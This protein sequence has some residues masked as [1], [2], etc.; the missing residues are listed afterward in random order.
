MIESNKIIVQRHLNR[1]KSQILEKDF[2]FLLPFSKEIVEDGFSIDFLDDIYQQIISKEYTGSYLS[3]ILNQKF[4]PITVKLF[5]WPHKDRVSDSAY[6]LGQHKT[7]IHSHP[8][9]CFFTTLRGKVKESLYTTTSLNSFVEKVEDKVFGIDDVGSDMADCGYIHSIQCD[10]SV[11]D[12]AVTLHLYAA[13][14]SV[15][16]SLYTKEHAYYLAK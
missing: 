14:P 7:H 15:I 10:S 4:D 5:F 11:D 1:Y 12:Y 13:S 3:Y 6:Q 8:I 9:A 2:G 16:E